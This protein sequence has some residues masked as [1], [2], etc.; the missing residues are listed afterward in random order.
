MLKVSHFFYYTVRS[1]HRPP[2]RKRPWFLKYKP[3]SWFQRSY[4]KNWNPM[5]PDGSV[6]WFNLWKVSMIL[7]LIPL[8]CYE[9]YKVKV[10]M[11]NGE[12]TN[13]DRLYNSYGIDL[14]FRS[15]TV[16]QEPECGEDCLFKW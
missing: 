3:P 15:K 2:D 16:G 8:N 5:G 11:E 13:A 1:Y 9:F 7:A 14:G 4:D 10:S 6:K 12:E